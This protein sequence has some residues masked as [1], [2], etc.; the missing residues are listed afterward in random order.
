[1]SLSAPGDRNPAGIPA[2]RAPG[3]VTGEDADHARSGHC[4]AAWRPT[5]GILYPFFLSHSSPVTY[6]PFHN[7]FP[8]GEKSAHE[9]DLHARDIARKA[10]SARV[11]GSPIVWLVV[12]LLMVVAGFGW[13]ERRVK[14]ETTAAVVEGRPGEP[15]ALPVTEEKNY[16][17][18][19][20]EPFLPITADSDEP[21]ADEFRQIEET[22]AAVAPLMS[23][24]Q[25]YEESGQLTY[26]PQENAWDLFTEILRLDPENAKARA[27]Q[28]RILA[29]LDS[30]VDA[31]IGEGEYETAERWIDELD[32]I[33]PGSAE[34]T[35][36]R[37]RIAEARRKEAE[38]RA[39]EAKRKEVEELLREAKIRLESSPPRT[40]EALQ[41]FRDA[42]AIDPGST[43]AKTGIDRLVEYHLVLAG[44]Y[45]K[46][47]EF[48]QAETEIR[49]AEVIEP[50]HEGVKN[51]RRELARERDRRLAEEQAAQIR[52]RMAEEEERRRQEAQRLE[53]ERRT[54]EKVA[55]RKTPG[56]RLLEAGILA[57][58][59][60]D[61]QRA[62]ELLHP[63]AEEGVARAQFRL[64]LMYVLG[65]GVAENR[66]EGLKWI[67]AALSV[68][69]TMAKKGIPWAQTDLGTAYELGLGLEKDMN[70]AIH[71]Y[72][73]AADR[74]YAGAQTNLGVLYASGD[75]V[76]WNRDL[77][78]QWL[79]RAARQG[80]RVAMENLKAL[81]APVTVRPAGETE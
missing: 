29:T 47:G 36:Y 79:Q 58:Y 24:A 70:K 72:T 42:L 30:E 37:N 53:E 68:I 14:P 32:R 28:K 69:V 40:T 16:E 67:K 52:Q 6:N 63:L 54:Q 5:S 49:I 77:A 11:L 12:T 25:Q 34:Q 15:G 75:G 39:A 46:K 73:E 51:A 66:A 38:Q 81:G 21:R 9:H 10:R 57:Y 71:W 61:Y 23:R 33:R 41:L 45:M 18:V 60:S 48:A 44:A 80:D 17:E 19:V 2:G 26:P 7:H 3:R 8:H 55:T 62:F 56:P 74:G 64:G 13:L 20:K 31:L 22:E 27:G 65:R 43:E 4:P 76:E 78:I 35:L 1:M 59:R 50:R